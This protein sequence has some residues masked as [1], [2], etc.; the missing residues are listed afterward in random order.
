MFS[1]DLEILINAPITRVFD[2]VSRIETCVY[3]V[4]EVQEAKTITPGPAKVGTIGIE[5]VRLPIGLKVP[6]EW[7]I[8]QLVENELCTFVSD[9]WVA[10]T[11]V[12][13]DLEAVDSN[14]RLN[15]RMRSEPKG[16]LKL[17]EP[18]LYRA[19]LV[20]RRRNLERLKAVLEVAEKQA[21]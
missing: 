15:Y 1:F 13:F 2:Y 11:T 12:S 3:W 6:V 10:S 8:S 19:A 16:L 14:T 5:V 21:T 20:G 18:V 7:R 4:P 17:A 9:S